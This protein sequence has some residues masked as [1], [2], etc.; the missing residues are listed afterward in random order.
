MG[1]GIGMSEQLSDRKA[2]LAL[3][4]EDSQDQLMLLRR[5][6]EREGFSVFGAVSAEAAIAAFDSISPS[7]AIVDLLLPGVSGAECAA[8]VRE[9][10]PDCA[11][12]I[13]S[14]LDAAGYPESDA[15]LPKPVTGASLHEAIE[16]VAA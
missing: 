5:M 6:L 8:L 14:V 13:S 3:V 15:A 16:R 4:V 2:R 9:R 10:F 1:E 11:I 12:V 7:V